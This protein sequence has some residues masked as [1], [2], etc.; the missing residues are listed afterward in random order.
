[1]LAKR[2]LRL[3]SKPMVKLQMF[4]IMVKILLLWALPL[5]NLLM[6]PWK[7]SMGKS[8]PTFVKKQGGCGI[9]LM[10][11]Q[12]FFGATILHLLHLDAQNIVFGA[13]THQKMFTDKCSPDVYRQMFSGCLKPNSQSPPLSSL[14]L[15][16]SYWTNLIKRSTVEKR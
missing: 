12:H 4:N 9:A 1:M 5:Q 6:R 2:I 11:I 13:L 3:F 7:L 16:G 8:G 14:L 15:G 10:Q